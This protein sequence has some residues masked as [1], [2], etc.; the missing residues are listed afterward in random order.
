MGQSAIDC[1]QQA[2]QRLLKSKV[3]WKRVCCSLRIIV[4]ERPRKSGSA[5]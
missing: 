3:A 5:P 1:R 2:P 4:D